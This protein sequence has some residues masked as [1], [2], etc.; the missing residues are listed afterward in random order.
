MMRTPPGEIKRVILKAVAGSTAHGLS[1]P[2][3][4]EDL[5]GVYSWPTRAYHGLWEPTESLVGHDPQ[6][7]TYHELKKFLLLACR[8]NPTV[9]ELLWMDSYLVKERHWGEELIALRSSMVSS[10]LVRDAYLG[11]AHSQFRKLQERGDGKFDSNTANRAPK[12][13]KHLFRLLEAGYDLLT[14]GDMSVRVHDRS[15]YEEIMLM[16]Q[17]QWQKLFDEERERFRSVKSVLRDEPDY[18]AVNT[19]LTNYR[20]AH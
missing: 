3:S 7:Y 14:T 10:K 17:S 20:E 4:D 15:R 1:T 5:Y 9:L 6:D 11:Y 13:A 8:S 12:H 18:E 2:D 16:T 19:F